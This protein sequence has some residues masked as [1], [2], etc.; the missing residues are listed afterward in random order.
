MSHHATVLL[1]LLRHGE[2]SGGECYRGQQ[3]DP[4]TEKGWRQ[5]RQAV[6][7][8]SG[9]DHLLSSPLRRCSEFADELAQ[10]TSL[11]L[12]VNPL[13]KEISFGEWE[14]RTA[15]DIEQTHAQALYNFWQDPVLY[16]PPGA[17]PLLDFERRIDNVLQT[18]IANHHHQHVLVICHAGVIRMILKQVLGLPIE[19]LFAIQI[20]HAALTRLQFEIYDGQVSSSLIFHNSQ[21]I[22]HEPIP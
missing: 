21:L 9:W 6:G 8:F 14:G 13:L 4:L 3:D 12:N 11:P 20:P 1:D 16:T 22:D 7:V 19:R 10:K 18:F 17:E 5:M 15:Q 2:P